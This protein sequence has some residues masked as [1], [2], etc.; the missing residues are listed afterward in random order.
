MVIDASLEAVFQKMG[1]GHR[2]RM[3]AVNQSRNRREIDDRNP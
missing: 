1:I 2:P 3:I